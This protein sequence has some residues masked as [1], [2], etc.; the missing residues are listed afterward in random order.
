MSHVSDHAWTKESNSD[1]GALMIVAAAGWLVL[2]GPAETPSGPKET[3][4]KPVL[5]RALL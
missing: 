3:P 1:I 4:S 5:Y 2:R